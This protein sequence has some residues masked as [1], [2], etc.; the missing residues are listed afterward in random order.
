MK[1]IKKIM[2]LTVLSLTVLVSCGKDE[3][4]SSNSE[5]KE[6]ITLVLDWN[7]NTNHTGLYVAK[8]R[9]YF[10]AEGLDVEIIQPAQDSSLDVVAQGSAQLGISY[11]EHVTVARA[12]ENPIPVVA[13]A[14]IIQ[15]NTTGFAAPASKGITRPKDFEGKTY[16]SYGTKLEEGLIK[17]LMEKDGGDFS[18][19]KIINNNATDFFAS[20]EKDM[21]FAWIFEAWDGVKADLMGKQINYIRLTD[22]DKKLDFYTPIIIT[23]EKYIKTNP[24]TIRKFLRATEKG[25]KFAIENPEEGAKDLLKNAQG[26]DEE[27]VIGSQKYLASKYID[28]AKYFGEMKEEVWDNFMNFLFDIGAIERKIDTKKAYTNEFLEK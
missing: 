14:A 7:P 25:Y 5:E 22:F 8:E 4:T 28:D 27:L 19:V 18:K 20:T 17:Y 24:E 11:Q 21:D 13:V 2:I 23:N 9:G 12:A 6:K 1:G 10:T 15:H 26:L 3:K 16:G